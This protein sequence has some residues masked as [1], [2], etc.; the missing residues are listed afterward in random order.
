MATSLHTLLISLCWSVKNKKSYDLVFFWRVFDADRAWLAAEIEM[1]EALVRD[2]FEDTLIPAVKT[3]LAD[4]LANM[5]DSEQRDEVLVKGLTSLH[6][7]CMEIMGLPVNHIDSKWSMRPYLIQ[8][9]SDYNGT[10]APREKVWNLPWRGVGDDDREDLG[11]LLRLGVPDCFIQCLCKEDMKETVVVETF[12][13]SKTLRLILNSIERDGNTKLALDALAELERE[14][15]H[16]L[17]RNN[18]IITQVT[19]LP[20]AD[21]SSGTAVIEG[22]PET[23]FNIRLEALIDH[24]KRLGWSVEENPDCF[25]LGPP[26]EDTYCSVSLRKD[27]RREDFVK[28]LLICFGH[29]SF[30]DVGIAVQKLLAYIQKVLN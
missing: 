27:A 14:T 7:D 11:F 30:D 17:A 10:Y 22:A 9:N 13:H 12:W 3:H 8:K 21:F 28:S 5:P 25:L 23:D 15:F 4:A 26:V 19:M 16:G 2:A 29:H 1:I 24:A 18:P 20:T 6:D